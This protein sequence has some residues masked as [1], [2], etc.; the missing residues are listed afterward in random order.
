[1]SNSQGRQLGALVFCG[2]SVPGIM[3]FPSLHPAVV[4]AATAVAIWLWQS[5]GQKNRSAL[6]AWGMAVVSVLCLGLVVNWAQAAYPSATN[7]W[8]M[9][10][11]LLAVATYA[12]RKGVRPLLRTAAIC[13]FFLVVIYAV[14]IVF[15]LGDIS[16][17]KQTGWNGLKE[18]NVNLVWLLLPLAVHWMDAG[19]PTR[20]W[21]WAWAAI[22]IMPCLVCWLSLSGNV[23]QAETFSFY[24]LTKS[25]S[26]LG[27]MERFEVIL[28]A[29]L[30][31][32]IFCLMGIFGHICGSVL[33]EQFPKAGEK[34]YYVV[35]AV[36]ALAA[37]VSTAW[38]RLLIAVLAPIFWGI[39]PVATQLIGLRK[40]S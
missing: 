37:L 7:Q 5:P 21:R 15:G 11:I 18:E 4:V 39:V 27:V 36:S 14:V 17:V 32:G 19:K 25:I 29:A 9:G 3:L 22:C 30:T 33:E 28:S 8:A 26:L 31:A 38:L 35:F 20:P 16:S 40:K 24:T 13:F 12:A 6:A 2:L 34:V 1:M 23:A 10:L